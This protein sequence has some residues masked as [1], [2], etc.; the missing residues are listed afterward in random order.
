MSNFGGRI[1]RKSGQTVEGSL[2]Q[3]G[4]SDEWDETYDIEFDGEIT[5]DVVRAMV[6]AFNNSDLANRD[7]SSYGALRWMCRDASVTVDRINRQIVVRRV[8]GIAD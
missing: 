4:W 7:S 1:L 8:M 2:R 3:A 5:N 6:E